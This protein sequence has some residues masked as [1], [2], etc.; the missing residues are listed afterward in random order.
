MS[1]TAVALLLLGAVDVVALS[2]G[3]S[4]RRRLTRIVGETAGSIEQHVKAGIA[5]AV[6]K[7]VTVAG[8]LL[9]A[10]GRGDVADRVLEE[11]RQ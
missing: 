4:I 7:I 9:R 8:E 11:L 1:G 3:I 5:E 6:S 10:Q 2:I